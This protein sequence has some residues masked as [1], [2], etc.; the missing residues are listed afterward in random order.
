MPMQATE[1]AAVVLIVAAAF[2]VFVPSRHLFLMLTLE[3]YTREMP[4]RKQNT[5]KFRRR[6][7]EWWARIPAAPVQLI[8]P[9]ETKKKKWQLAIRREKE[10]WNFSISSQFQP[11]QLTCPYFNLDCSDIS[12][13]V[14]KLLPIIARITNVQKD[15]HGCKNMSNPQSPTPSL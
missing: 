9:N 1:V 14:I 8:R 4:L 10:T 12:S 13:F 3:L 11:D 2:L 7:R 6:I 5:E 15:W